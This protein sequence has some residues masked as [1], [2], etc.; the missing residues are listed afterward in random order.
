MSGCCH[1]EPFDHICQG[2]QFT[3][4][5]YTIQAPLVVYSSIWSVKV[6]QRRRQ[7]ASKRMLPIN[8]AARHHAQNA[9][10]TPGPLLKRVRGFRERLEV[11][12]VMFVCKWQA[13]VAARR[14]L[15]LVGVDEDPGVSGRAAAAVA[16]NDALVRPADGLLVNHLHGGLGLGLLFG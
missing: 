12:P 9:S 6:V 10:P 2:A 7:H 4:Q 16:G 11:L 13:A 15:G 5:E 1:H 3:H 8:F 14:D